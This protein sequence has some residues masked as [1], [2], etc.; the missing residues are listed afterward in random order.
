MKK[1]TKKKRTRKPKRYVLVWDSGL[2]DPVEIRESLDDLK[3]RIE[4]LRNNDSIGSSDEIEVYELG[5][6]KEVSI[7]E[8]IIK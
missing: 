3:E 8:V 2:D 5:K 1:E 4:E 6:E 7:G